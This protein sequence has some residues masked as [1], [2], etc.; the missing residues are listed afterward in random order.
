MC[1]RRN[2]EGGMPQRDFQLAKYPKTIQCR[3]GLE[4][5]VR[6]ME[7]GDFDIVRAFFTNLPMEDR[8]FLRD[9]ATRPEVLAGWFVGLDY[10]KRIP[11]LALHGG[12]VVGHALLDGEQRGWSRHVAE[13]RVVVADAYKKRAVGSVLARELFD[14]AN[15]MGF[16]KVIGQ[17]MDTQSA[18]RTMFERMG[19]VAEARLAG[20]IKDL[21]GEKH[22]LLI[23][24]CSLDDAWARMQELLDDISVTALES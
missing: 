7:A 19:F 10:A 12:E 9:D 8:L 17:M 20:H 22:D 23:M 4:V 16:E 24:S 3:D 18:A 6:P 11:I 21:S 1:G 5:T 2:R 13:V 15:S 14:L